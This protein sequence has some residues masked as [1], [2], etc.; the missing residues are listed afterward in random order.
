MKIFN[1]TE[2]S[3]LYTS[4]VFLIL[5]AWNTIDDVNTLI[6][7]GSD[8][9]IVSRIEGINTGL[10]KKKIDQVIL[11]HSHS[12]HAATLPAI[13]KAFNPRVYAYNSHLRGVDRF[14]KDGDLLRI[15][16]MQFEVIHTTIHSSDSICL[17]CKENGILF[18]G[19]T[20]IPNDFQLQNSINSYPE[21][22]LENW[23]F[24]KTIYFGH[25][26]VKYKVSQTV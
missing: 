22:L 9:S 21:R 12:D 7:V 19:D 25:G 10:G 11:T 5:G 26:E 20:P 18:V 14:L 8:D 1:L 13:M 24:V 23:E 15:G 16:E 17:F 6:D 3:R 2:N 4:N